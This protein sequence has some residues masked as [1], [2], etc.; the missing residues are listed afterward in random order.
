MENVIYTHSVTVD[1]PTMIV[2][3]VRVRNECDL[4]LMWRRTQYWK[5]NS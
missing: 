5:I 1:M 4:E 2:L 3:S